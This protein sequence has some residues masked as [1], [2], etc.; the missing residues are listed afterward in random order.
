MSEKYVTAISDGRISTSGF[1]GKTWRY[2]SEAE[3]IEVIHKLIAMDYA[4][5]HQP[6][7]WPPAAV[8]ED[9]QEKGKSFRMERSNYKRM[10]SDPAELGR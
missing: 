5:V 6:A 4:F 8:L 7:G 3:L 10:Q 9:L 1:F 2:S